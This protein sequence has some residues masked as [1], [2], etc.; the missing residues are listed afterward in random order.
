MATSLSEEEMGSA[1][2]TGNLNPLKFLGVVTVIGF[3]F[4][5]IFNAQEFLSQGFRTSILY[6]NQELNS[7]TA[8]DPNNGFPNQYFNLKYSDGNCINGTNRRPFSLTSCSFNIFSLGGQGFAFVP[9]Y[10]VIIKLGAFDK[11]RN[12]QCL[13]SVMNIT[14]CDR[15]SGVWRYDPNLKQIQ[16]GSLST[17]TWLSNGKCI[18]RH[19]NTVRLET[20]PSQTTSSQYVYTLTPTTGTNYPLS[21]LKYKLATTLPVPPLPNI[22]KIQSLNNLEPSCI[23]LPNPYTSGVTLVM[24]SCAG[25]FSKSIL[26]T[27]NVDSYGNIMKDNT[28]TKNDLKSLCL[29][30]NDGGALNLTYCSVTS[31][32]RQSFRYDLTSKQISLTSA[33]KMC[34][35]SSGAIGSSLSFVPCL[36]GANPPKYQQFGFIDATTLTPSPSMAPVTL[37]VKGDDDDEA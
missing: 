9:G 4:L 1:K 31:L 13:S 24:R 30:S 22:F 28:W 35:N 18:N 17:G 37:K 25:V 6:S 5:L 27:F 29:D 16:S 21:F 14:A 23:T 36:N 11:V 34:L 7:K 20:C 19:G 26:Q 3:S 8:Y 33:P 15:N 2:W 12:N 10:N 32:Y